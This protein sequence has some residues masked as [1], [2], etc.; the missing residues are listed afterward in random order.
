MGT[1]ELPES[2]PIRLVLFDLD[3][4]LADTAPDLAFALNQTLVRHGRQPLAFEE[5]R[6]QVSHGGAAMI[7]L[8]FGIQESDPAFIELR[9]EFLSLYVSNLARETTLFPGMGEL[10]SALEQRNVR[11]GIVTNKPSWLTDPLV[12]QLQLTPRAVCVISGDTT[13]NRKPHPEP[14]L[15]ACNLAGAIPAETLYVGDAERDIRAG[16]LAGA[17]TLTA[18]FGYIGMGDNPD[19]WH[20]DGVI[21]H[22]LQI[23]DWL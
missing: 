15:H 8:G 16:R 22:P 19:E 13:T 17:T 5:I 23:L 4:T 14:I 18:A 6:P 10:I 11:W 20:A 7:K 2:N 21:S 1:V 9:E 3:G 12:E